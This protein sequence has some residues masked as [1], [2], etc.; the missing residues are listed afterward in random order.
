MKT[1]ERKPTYEELWKEVEMLRKANSD[2][3]HDYS[4]LL[5]KYNEVL[6]SRFRKSSEIID[7]SQLSLFDEAELDACDG[8]F[9]DDEEKDNAPAKDEDGVKEKTRKYIRRKIRNAALTL[10]ANT[11]VKEIHVKSIAPDCSVCGA[12]EVKTGERVYEYVAK[13]TSYTIVR[14]IVDVYSC[15]N[16]EGDGNKTTADE[17][18]MLKGTVCDP[19]MLASI[20]DSKMGNGLPLYRIAEN[21]RRDGINISRHLISSWVMHAGSA[22]LKNYEPVLEQEVMGCALV[23]ADETPVKVLSLVDEDGN[24]KAPN[25]RSNAYMLVRAGTNKD[26]SPGPVVFSF[27]D[28]RRNDTI[29]GYFKDYRGLLQTDG[30]YGYENAAELNPDL[31]HLGC[32]VHARRKAVEAAGDRKTGEAA[33][34]VGLYGQIFHEEGIL[35]DAYRDGTMTEEDFL[36]KRKEK[37]LPLF[38]NL[39]KHMEELLRLNLN[40]KLRKA[41][42]YYIDRYD[43]LIRFLNHSY[44]TSSNQK[45]E[46]AIRPFVIGRKGWLF[47]ITEE[48]V[49]VSALYY[50]IVETCKA[51]G[52]NAVEYLT[53]LFM[54]AASIEDGD[55]E[56]WRDILPGHCDLADAREYIASLASAAP[57]ADRTEP[58]VLRG[59]KNK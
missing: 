12:K 33:N 3:E 42:E 2:W 10:P 51:L 29:H 26:L 8:A 40:G 15:P 45:A 14:K 21:F 43:T 28:N 46:N 19:Y 4:A 30:L 36:E 58:Y 49:K 59:K 13:H 24:K 9:N 22:L 23:N 34:L 35:N 56:G 57:D 27:T 44:A 53:H 47:C 50:S 31:S 20:I 48:G 52:I 16:C 25:S 5:R 6:A 54:N 32:L 39:K 7:K 41:C 11:P 17:G 38:E 37:L 1:E 55:I 18:N